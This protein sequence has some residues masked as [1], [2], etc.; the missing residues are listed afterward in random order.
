MEESSSKEASQVREDTTS[1]V[2]PSIS[3]TPNLITH[4]WGAEGME[5]TYNNSLQ[6][7][8]QRKKIWSFY[9][10]PRLINTRLSYV[11]EFEEATTRHAYRWLTTKLDHYSPIMVWEFYTSYA[12]AIL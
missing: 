5:A 3:S 12:T 10:D 2:A 1:L 6:P 7:K 11:P 8:G 4:R 9:E